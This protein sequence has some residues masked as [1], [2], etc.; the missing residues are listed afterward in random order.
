MLANA[1]LIVNN[2]WTD[3]YEAVFACFKVPHSFELLLWDNE[4]NRKIFVM[5]DGLWICNQPMISRQQIKPAGINPGNVTRDN[6]F[7]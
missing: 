4:G 1:K 3:V 2:E 6:F 5:F 7:M